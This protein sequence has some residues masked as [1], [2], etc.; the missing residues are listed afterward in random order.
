MQSDYRS[1]DFEARHANPAW[2]ERADFIIAMNIAETSGRSEWEQLWARKISDR[3]F[4]VCCIPF[5]AYDLALGDIVETDTSY[6]VTGVVEGSGHSTFRVWLQN[7]S[8][9]T[10]REVEAYLA[11]QGH[12]HEF[13]SE[14]LISIDS[15][16]DESAQALADFLQSMESSGR[17]TY[18]TGRSR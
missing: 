1:G 10:R 11:K 15:E 5:F 4:E 8:E 6:L 13:Y 17:L 3:R 2:R 14:H 16:D 7:A 9:A 12:R 18:E